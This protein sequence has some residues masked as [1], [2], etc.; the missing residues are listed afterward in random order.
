MT[1]QE[2]S[3]LLESTEL[4]VAYYSFKASDKVNIPSPP[5]IVYL[6][7]NS[8][9]IAADDKVYAKSGT[10]HIEL[11]S[12]QKD[13]ESEQKIE[14]ALDNAGIYYDKSETFI[15]TENLFEI[16]YEIEI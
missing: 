5:Y 9:N 2:L 3:I 11:Y 16:L 1:Q 6:F 8:D 4:P 7:I 15:D 14:D 13:L 10:Y 12:D